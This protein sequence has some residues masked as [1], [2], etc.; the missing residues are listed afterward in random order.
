MTDVKHARAAPQIFGVQ[1][2]SEMNRT[3][4]V[5]P[6]STTPYIATTTTTTTT[7]TTT[8]TTT[9]TTS[10]INMFVSGELSQT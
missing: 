8:T 6:C 10:V 4:P 7:A 3:R 1:Y 5:C 9:T 2:K